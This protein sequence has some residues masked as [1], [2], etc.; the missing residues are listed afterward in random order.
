MRG[1]ILLAYLAEEERDQLIKKA[2]MIKI[3]PKTITDPKE[4]IQVLKKIRAVGYHYSEGEYIN[5][6]WGLGAPILNHRGGA[7]GAIVISGAIAPGRRPIISKMV[8]VLCQTTQ[9]ISQE[10]GYLNKQA[11]NHLMSR[12]PKSGAADIITAKRNISPEHE[13]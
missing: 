4:L 8:K 1:K 3:T 11:P 6:A 12:S 13:G 2:K 5:G 10:M 7:E 9:A